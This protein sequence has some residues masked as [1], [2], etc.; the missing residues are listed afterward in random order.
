MKKE[1]QKHI[2]ILEKMR[3]ETH[4]TDKRHALKAAIEEMQLAIP[5]KPID[6]GKRDPKMCPN[7][8]EYLT[9]PL[10]TGIYIDVAEM[11]SCPACR[12]LLDMD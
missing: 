5:E 2:K 3:M 9:Q 6:N 10:G 1:I 11:I 4:D 7:C 12:Q 8:E